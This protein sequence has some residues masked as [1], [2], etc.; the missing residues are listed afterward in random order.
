MRQ[1][2]IHTYH[3]QISAP[4]PP[5]PTLEATFDLLAAV[6]RGIE[7]VVAEGA[8]GEVWLLGEEEGLVGRRAC[9]LASAVGPQPSHGTHQ[10]ALAD[11]AANR[12]ESQRRAS[13]PS[14]VWRRSWK[15]VDGVE[16]PRERVQG[17]SP[18]PSPPR[19]PR[20]PRPSPSVVGREKL[21][22]SDLRPTT[23]ENCPGLTVHDKP[24]TN[25]RS[26][27]AKKAPDQMHSLGLGSRIQGRGTAGG[28][29]MGAWSEEAL[30]VI[31]KGSG[32]G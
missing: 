29:W 25:I 23:S 24:C 30:K 1:R 8:E 26:D 14:V 4:Q 2:S 17:T 11:P 20:R 5:N 22:S 28:G 9:D 6:G 12:A 3:A 19:S 16:C 13:E 32:G 27:S 18:R 10:R 7:D 21:G 15:G 31:K